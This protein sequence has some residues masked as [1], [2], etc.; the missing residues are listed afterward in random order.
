MIKRDM[1]HVLRQALE[2]YPV[3]SVSGP[4]QCG[5]TTLLRS[6][7]PD[8]DYVSLEDPDV[9]QLAVDDPRAFLR[10]RHWHVI[11][12]EIQRAPELLS[13]L[14]GMVD[15]TG[16][17][18]QF[19]ISGSQNYLLMRSVTQ[20]LAGRVALV[21]MG[22]LSRHE[23]LGASAVDL[24]APDRGSAPLGAVR[25]DR[26]EWVVRGGYP[27]IYDYGIP[28]DR[29]YA[30]YV[31]TYLERDVRGEV[32]VIKLLDF[33]RFMGVCASRTGELLNYS[34]LASDTGID[35]KTAKGWLSALEASGILF[36]LRSH[37]SNAGKRFTKSPKLYFYDT[38]LAC[39]LLGIRTG[40]EAF[41]YTKSGNLFETA[42]VAE[43]LKCIRATGE[44]PNVTYYRKGG[45][46]KE[47]DL[48]AER[49]LEPWYAFEVKSSS[50]YRDK[51]FSNITSL[52]DELGVPVD[53]R[54]VIYNGE[55]GSVGN[56]QGLLLTPD[57]LPSLADGSVFALRARDR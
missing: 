23:L 42:V 57:D 11:F 37:F 51:F 52:A 54:G 6:E 36:E 1:A 12:D 20:T 17:P 38:G 41:A 16:E 48:V 47:I 24:S 4:R 26:W 50:T 21:D 14:Q 33:E 15:E 13:Y 56:R 49:G 10:H 32:G 45:S 25:D 43:Y 31:Q 40:E 46:E 22:T 2:E 5:K 19:A 53:R 55:E 39:H 9:R 34:A 8:W 28:S 44:R 27:R 3:V 7:L 35:V 30:D 29:Y 18:G